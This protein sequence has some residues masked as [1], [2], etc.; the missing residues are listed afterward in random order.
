MAEGTGF[1]Q[2]IKETA[3]NCPKSSRQ[4]QKEVIGKMEPVSSQMWVNTK[5]E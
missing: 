1:V 5:H 3:H 2:P 4:Y